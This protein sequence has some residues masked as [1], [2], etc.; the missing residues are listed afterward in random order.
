MSDRDQILRDLATMNSRLV[1]AILVGSES[2][3]RITSVKLD[4]DLTEADR[5]AFADFA[6]NGW[7]LDVDV[8]G[9]VRRSVLFPIPHHNDDEAP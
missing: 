6:Q 1:A 7:S 9:T 4:S 2:A 5:R 8:F 3:F